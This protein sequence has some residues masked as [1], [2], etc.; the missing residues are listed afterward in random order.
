V[1]VPL[2]VPVQ[3]DRSTARE[4]LARELAGSEYREAQ[5]SWLARAWAWIQDRLE[6]V[7]VPGLGT[8]WTAVLVVVVLLAAVIAVVLLVGG[9]LR[10]SARQAGAEPVFD[11]APEPAAAHVARADAAAAA[12]DFS[13]AVAERFRGLV[14]S[15]EERTLIQPRPGRTAVEIATEAGTALP[16]VADA[17]H[18]AARTFEDVR[19]GGRTAGPSADDD[20]RSVLDQVSR[21]RPAVLPAV[22]S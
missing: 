21:A 6:G 1:S 9:P 7:R 4:W 8:N 12:G 20:L 2:G 19:Y 15:L 5:G 13:L 10:R 14:R 11:A 16:D 22:L 3:P 17:L 18:R